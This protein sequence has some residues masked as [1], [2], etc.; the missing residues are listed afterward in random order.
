MWASWVDAPLEEA[1]N[2]DHSP[3]PAKAA[4]FLGGIQE[5]LL[6]MDT[7]AAIILVAI[8]LVGMALLIV[9]LAFK[10]TAAPFHS[11][12]PDVYQGAASGVSA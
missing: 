9:G 8:L 12:A 11:W 10:V 2:P 1:A 5:L 6:H 4:W 3:N 7:L